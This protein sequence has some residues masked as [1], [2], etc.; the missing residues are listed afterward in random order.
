MKPVLHG[1]I[2]ALQAG[3]E[4]LLWLDFI[5]SLA[6]TQFRSL[7]IIYGTVGI[8]TTCYFSCVIFFKIHFC[9]LGWK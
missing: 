4:V 9:M 3:S 6:K 7:G 8:N 5:F 1:I 2:V